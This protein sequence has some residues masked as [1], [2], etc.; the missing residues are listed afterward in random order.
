[1]SHQVRRLTSFLAHHVINDDVSCPPDAGYH[2]LEEWIEGDGTRPVRARSRR[3][4][5][6]AFNDLRRVAA[7]RSTSSVHLVDHDADGLRVADQ[8]LASRQLH[9]V[10]TSCDVAI[11]FV[12]T[13]GRHIDELIANANRRKRAYACVLDQAASRLIEGAVNEMTVRIDLALPSILGTT[14]RFSPGYCDWPLGEQEK[15]FALIGPDRHGVV[16][17]D[18]L[19][20]H[21][22]KSVS[23]I[24]GVGPTDAVRATGNPCRW[25][26]KHTCDHRR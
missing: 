1:M 26:R 19:L 6:Q 9:R 4:R 7:I 20:M 15:L 10:L 23:G 22:R 17:E 24:I 12:I 3:L 25:C 11:T 8:A 5:Q 18:G 14:H 13:L 16:L 21:P 2:A